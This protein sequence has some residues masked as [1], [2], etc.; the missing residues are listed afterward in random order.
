MTGSGLD[1]RQEPMKTPLR[2]ILAR[3]LLATLAR[4]DWVLVQKADTAGQAIEITT[5]IQGDLARVDEGDK[6]TVIVG[7]EGLTMMGKSVSPLLVSAE[8]ETLAAKAFVPQT[9]STIVSALRALRQSNPEDG[10]RTPP[11]VINRGRTS[12]L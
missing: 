11:L 5:K 9:L 12:F 10:G 4:A 6:M 2:S 3:L 8:E 7:A 1:L